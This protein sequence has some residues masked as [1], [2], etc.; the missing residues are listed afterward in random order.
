MRRHFVQLV[1]QRLVPPQEQPARQ[2]PPEAQPWRSQ[3]Q[4]L[5]RALPVRQRQNRLESP[6]CRREQ[7]FELHSVPRDCPQ[8]KTEL[9]H[10]FAQ[11]GRRVMPQLARRRPA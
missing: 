6:G 3:P 1:R 2:K 4:A 5:R 8:K 10:L 7:P 9:R 11:R